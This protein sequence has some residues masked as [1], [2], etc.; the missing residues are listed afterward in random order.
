[1]AC[2]RIAHRSKAEVP[3]QK[4]LPHNDDRRHDNDSRLV[5]QLA[6]LEYQTPFRVSKGTLLVEMERGGS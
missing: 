1:V 6:G 4:P 3:V 2:W 5:G